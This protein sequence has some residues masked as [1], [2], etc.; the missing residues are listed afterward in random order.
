MGQRLG[1][2]LIL[3]S[4]AVASSH[5]QAR[6]SPSTDKYR[7]VWNDDPATS[8]VVEWN[9]LS[10]SDPAVYYGPEDHGTDYILYPHMQEPT[11]V[12]YYRGMHNHFVK[13]TGLTPD[14]P[15][16]FVIVDSEGVSER[17]WFKTAPDTPR[18]FTFISGGDTKSYGD[19]LQA[20]RFSHQMVPKLRPLFVIFKGDFT[21][22]GGI[23]DSEWHTWFDDWAT[24]TKASDGRMFPLIPVQ[25]NHENGDKTVLHKLFDAPYQEGDMANIYYAL[26]FG[27]NLLRIIVLN[28]EIEEGGEQRLWLENELT[29]SQDHSFR[30]TAYHKPFRPHTSSKPDQDYQYEQWAQLFYDY[31][32]NLSFDADS[33][34]HKI[35]YPLRP[36]TEAGS[37]EGFIRDD[38]L[39]TMYLRELG[40]FVPPQ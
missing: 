34:M 32:V 2:I 11:R 10:G 15:Y 14:T 31:G 22:D 20:G 12:E 35:T 38:E 26:S 39:G 29:A 21:S 13:L 18:P 28:S 27:G 5:G 16:Y 1:T 6:G 3:L 7:L 40:S 37:F 30:L 23:V 8:V 33:H 17:M 4:L 19:A 25:G 24:L 36:S 9:Q